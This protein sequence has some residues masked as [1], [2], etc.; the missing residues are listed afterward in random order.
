MARY[1]RFVDASIRERGLPPELL[2]LPLLESRYSAR[3]VSRSGASGLWQ[4]MGNTS[5][6]L[7][8]RSDEW[9][10]ERRDF[11]KA[12]QAALRKLD[13]NHRQFGDWYL[14]LAA[15]NCGSGCLRRLLAVSGTRDFWEL[16]ERGLLR[17]ETAEYVPA[18]IALSRIVASP[19]RYGLREGWEPRRSG[20]GSG[21]ARSVDL[22][23]LARALEL[24]YAELR[25]ANAELKYPVTPP[26]REATG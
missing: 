11:W 26:Y 10:D 14:A 22:R 24:E 12:T 15:Y 23:L 2:V 3:A 13:D 5:G 9:L 1:R 25:E 20:R 16:R 6:A 21:G 18:F 7:G 4:I 19:A 8:L 17:R